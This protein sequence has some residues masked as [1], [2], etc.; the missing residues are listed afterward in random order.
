MNPQDAQPQMPT[1]PQ[2]PQVI[3]PQQTVPPTVEQ[4]RPQPFEPVPIAAPESAPVQPSI[5]EYQPTPPPVAAPEVP[6]APLPPPPPQAIA[7]APLVQPLP[8]P[9]TQPINSPLAPAYPGAAGGAGLPTANK[10]RFIIIGAIVAAVIVV[11]A[12]ALFVFMSMSKISKEDYQKANTAIGD[13]TKAVSKSTSDLTGTSYGLSYDTPTTANN[14]YETAKK[15]L[16][17]YKAANSKLK[18]LKAFS[19]SDIKAK[20]K[21]Y[22]QKFDAYVNY[23]NNYIDSY[24]KV[25]PGFIAYED[26][27][28]ASSGGVAAYKTQLASAQKIFE[29]ASNVPDKDI[30]ALSKEMASATSTLAQLVDQLSSTP[31]S[32]YAKQSS[33][34]S[35]GY[36]VD[37]KVSNALKDF[38]SNQGKHFDEVDP[39][40]SARDLS[41]AVFN[42]YLSKSLKK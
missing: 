4:A 41:D 17:E 22:Q 28:T 36:D 16:E 40:K 6:V 19:D 12:A 30:A 8:P 1:D 31:A 3:S 23:A 11:I 7:A 2:Q 34:R 5:P 35:Q 20:N 37:T 38:K 29:D 18:G 15:S 14:K 27:I 24:N 26:T 21:I 32:D 39:S 13:V 33:I 42:K 25:Y 10:K 9:P